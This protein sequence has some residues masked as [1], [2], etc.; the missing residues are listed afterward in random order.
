MSK[1]L[2]IF[3][4]GPVQPF[5]AE[6]RKTR[7]LAAGS[8]ILS[9]L[10]LEA[11]SFLERAGVMKREED[12]I[13]PFYNIYKFPNRFLCLI[14]TENPQK[15]GKDLEEYI[16][17]NAFV[18]KALNTISKAIQ[19]EE[20]QESTSEQLSDAL[21]IYWASIPYSASTYRTDYS[22]LEQLLGGVKSLRQVNYLEEKGR[23][24]GIDGRYNTKYYRN[25]KD[26]K[27]VLGDRKKL[28]SKDAIVAKY[29]D[30]IPKI[31]DLQPGEGLSAV[32][33]FKRLY[34]PLNEDENWDFPSTAEFALAD[35]LNTLLKSATGTNAG[36]L[37][38]AIQCI[39]KFNAQFFYEE[40]VRLKTF[41][42]LISDNHIR[43]NHDM[44]VEWQRNI[45][46]ETRKHK[47]NLKLS[48]Y[49]AV[50]LFDADKM[51]EILSGG[52]NKNMD[53]LYSFQK[54]LAEKIAE[55]A[56]FAVMAVD[57][58][59]KDQ[60]I[61]YKGKAVY[62]G[63]DDFLAF[64]NL[65]HL[66][67]LMTDLRNLF[68]E[69]VHNELESYFSQEDK[70]RTFTFSA[71]AVIAHYKTPLS[72][73]IK[74]ARKAVE[75]AK[76]ETLGNRNAFAIT[77]LKKSGEIERTI[78][79]WEANP[80]ND[81]KLK[82]NAQ[83]LHRLVNRLQAKELSN[84]FITSFERLFSPLQNSKGFLELNAAI[85]HTELKRL[86]LRSDLS[87][88][89]KKV[90][91]EALADELFALYQLNFENRLPLPNFIAF[92][93]IA[94]FIRKEANKISLAK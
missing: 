11:L 32:C 48:K 85:I 30:N 58:I 57:E 21:K 61:Y 89:K 36:E 64:V 26:E 12:L 28:F 86:M 1:H 43:L 92:L 66:L 76:D 37:K 14:K 69:M 77:S 63:G 72:I 3:T 6:A 84:T 83:L 70:K 94:D 25:L 59:E 60:G 62:H 4:V 19:K 5:I 71:G 13:F 50:L 87:G 74:E 44:V 29:R 40:N 81:K 88:G 65:T 54:L 22:F 56:D 73:V 47:E 18:D 38:M 93:T 39:R 68:G 23:K 46:I 75:A 16:R 7:D 45:A 82:L 33:F 20:F 24:C 91:I 17:D 80:F 90:E 49:Y 51:G 78:C 67:P 10:T 9:D 79:K 42:K 35:T 53:G 31:K 15:V 8:S 34:Q 2:F 52:W 27:E 55:F 41:E